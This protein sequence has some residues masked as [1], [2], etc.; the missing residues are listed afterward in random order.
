MATQ[1][2]IAADADDEWM[3]DPLWEL[4][5]TLQR[6]ADAAAADSA[7]SFPLLLLMLIVV[8]VHNNGVRP[9]PPRRC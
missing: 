2:E 4:I 7:S 1:S 5:D 6:S 3:E 8:N 9:S